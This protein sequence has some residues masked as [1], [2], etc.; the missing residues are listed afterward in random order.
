VSRFKERNGYSLNPH[1]YPPHKGEGGVNVE[2][3]SPLWG[4]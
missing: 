4:G 1:P 3:P 2:V